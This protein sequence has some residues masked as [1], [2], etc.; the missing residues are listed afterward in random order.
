MAGKWS[1]FGPGN[2]KNVD[3]SRGRRRDRGKRDSGNMTNALDELELN[4]PKQESGGPNARKRELVNRT[5]FVIEFAWTP[6]RPR[7][8]PGSPSGSLDGAAASTAG[9]TGGTASSRPA[10]STAAPKK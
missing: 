5:N 8:K 2:N 1:G 6:D 10:S 4:D 7:P 3:F 9:G